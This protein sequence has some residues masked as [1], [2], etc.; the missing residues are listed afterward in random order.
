MTRLVQAVRV[1]GVVGAFF[2]FLKKLSEMRML[3]TFYVAKND[4]RRVTFICLKTIKLR[5]ACGRTATHGALARRVRAAW[6][7]NKIKRRERAKMNNETLS[8]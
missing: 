2:C 1:A 8:R 7:K 5:S 6:Q 4:H 3:T